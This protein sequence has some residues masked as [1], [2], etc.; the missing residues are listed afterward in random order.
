VDAEHGT[1]SA[2][3]GDHRPEDVARTLFESGVRLRGLHVDRPDL[4][5]LFVSITGEGFDVL[6]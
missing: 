6:N 3:L 1:V 4:E 2:P 5:E